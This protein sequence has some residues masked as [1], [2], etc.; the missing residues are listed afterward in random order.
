MRNARQQ[1]QRSSV[2]TSSPE[3]LIDKLYREAISACHQGDR[4]YLRELLVELRSSIDLEQGDDLAERLMAIYDYCLEESATGDLD[5]V[6]ELL[7]EL[8]DAWRE[9]V[10]G[11]QAA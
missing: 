5:V 3:K 2:Q 6:Q 10:L 1:Y 4:E 9:G 8:R 7:S 11:K